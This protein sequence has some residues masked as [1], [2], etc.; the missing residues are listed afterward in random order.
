MAALLG[1]PGQ[2]N[3]AAANAGMDSLALALTHTGAPGVASVQWGAWG[4]GGMAA[5]DAATLSRVKRTGMSFLDPAS[6]LAALSRLLSFPG[7]ATAQTSVNAFS[8]DIFLDRFGGAVPEL[9]AE[10]AP[11]V[12]GAQR[13]A[14]QRD[15]DTRRAGGADSAVSA[16]ERAAF[17]EEQVRDAVSSVLGGVLPAPEE[18]LTA[19]GLDSLAA[20][21][22]RN[23]LESRL[24]ARLSA[25]LIF[26]YPSLSA[27][28]GYLQET[29]AP[30]TS[31]TP[32]FVGAQANEG[33][34]L[35]ASQ[36]SFVG[37]AQRGSVLVVTGAASRLPKNAAG[38][39]GPMDCISVL[40]LG[41]WDPETAIAADPG[42]MAARFGGFVEGIEE[43]DRLQF[44]IS[45][46]EAMLMDVQQR[47]LLEWGLE[48]G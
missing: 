3:Y 27:L 21:D 30:S 32:T 12:A 40:P 38:L 26:D 29:L 39:V 4:G 33:E 8:W 15:G 20:V 42:V 28:T 13:G 45:Q 22:L 46:G 6:S 47:L 48:V 35:S 7:T 5:Q 2:T 31:T 14:A 25:T 41:R 24:G 36:V 1:S 44:G 17:V 19:A 34:T 9:F 11:A 43:F 23:S 37:D 10:F 16:A 18:P